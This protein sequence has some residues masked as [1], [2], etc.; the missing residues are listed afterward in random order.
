M[1][2]H[3]AFL[4]E[5]SARRNLPVWEWGKESKVLAVVLTAM[6]VGLGIM[7]IQAG[8]EK[9]WG[10]M[11][12]AF[13]HHNGAGVVSLAGSGHPVYSWWGIFQH[14]F[15]VPNAAWIAILVAVSEFAV[16]VALTLGLFTRLAALGSLALLFTYMMSGSSGGVL[17][18]LFA[19]II[20][21]MWRTASWIGIDGLLAGYR[22]RHQGKHAGHPHLHVPRPRFPW[23]R[24][25]AGTAGGRGG[26]A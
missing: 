16:G 12:P 8:T 13:L 4:G 25:T 26:P 11:N 7:W 18:A 17:H 23:E 19:V 10:A 9:L 6:R 20:L 1:T 21:A 2:N 3:V 5:P 15:V 24:S 14:G 22:Q